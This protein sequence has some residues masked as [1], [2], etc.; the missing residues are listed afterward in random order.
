MTEYR[1]AA[2][3]LHRLDEIFDYTCDRWGEAQAERYLRGMLD[4]FEA[5]AARRIPWRAI[6]AEFG[7]NGYFCRYERHMIYW[8]ELSDGR[9]GIVTILHERMHAIGRLSAEFSD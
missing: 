4:R 2:R 6:P 1:L 9:I 7:V 5:V 8:K 3:A